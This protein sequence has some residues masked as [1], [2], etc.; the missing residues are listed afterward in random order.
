MFKKIAVAAALVL[1]AS[2]SFAAERAYIYAGADFGTTDIDGLAGRSTSFGSFIGYQF[3]AN[4]G[5]EA[6]IR[7]LADTTE[8]FTDVRVVQMGLSLVGTL[9]LS[10]GLNVFGRVGHNKLEGRASAGNVVRGET[11]NKSMYG[12]GVGYA[13]TPVISGRVEIQK[14]TN[15]G[16][17]A[18]ASIVF[19]F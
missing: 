12:V 16:N 14:L 1:L 18:S 19:K 13:F 4:L 9:P 17:N 7:R 6:N 5:V 8:R 15:F 11:V 3:T 10:N 2:S